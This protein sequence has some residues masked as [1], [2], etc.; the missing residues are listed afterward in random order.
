MDYRKYYYLE[1]YLLGDVL[2]RFRATGKLS[3]F[4]F[5]CILVWK[6]NRAKKK[7]M[8]R[9]QRISGQTY[10]K[11]VACLISELLRSPNPKERLGVLMQD[12]GFRLPTASAILTILY[13]DDFTVYDMRVCGELGK[14]RELANRKFTER[15]WDDYVKFKDRVVRETPSHYCLRDKDRYLWGKS[16]YKQVRNEST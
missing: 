5:H 16:F 14:F 7:H 11:S 6:A 15:L 1:A 10:R 3:A 4:H 13:P 9:L 8:D 12:W 2:D